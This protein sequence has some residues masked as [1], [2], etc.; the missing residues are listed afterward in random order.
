MSRAR[1]PHFGPWPFGP[2]EQSSR[3]AEQQSSR[4]EQAPGHRPQGTGPSPPPHTQG[5]SRAEESS[6][7]EQ[8][9][10]PEGAR[11][12]F[13]SLDLQANFV[14][15]R[16]SSHSCRVLGHLTNAKKYLD[17]G[18]TAQ[19]LQKSRH[20]P[21]LPVVPCVG[22]YGLPPNHTHPPPTHTYL[23]SSSYQIRVY[24]P[25]G[26]GVRSAMC[27]D[28]P[29]RCCRRHR[30]SSASSSVVAVSS[31][32]SSV[33]ALVVTVKRER[34]REREIYFHSRPQHVISTRWRV[35]CV[36]LALGP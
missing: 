19:S 36:I 10:G 5:P 13:G 7:A 35:H 33:V 30:Q 29:S 14:F 20:S 2:P 21:P 6:R 34:A 11:D 25:W 16:L 3:A 15:N 12:T 18:R 17:L 23:R 24:T 26:G 28:T 4:A 22:A 1:R 8:S 9:T 27:I 32:S 31:A